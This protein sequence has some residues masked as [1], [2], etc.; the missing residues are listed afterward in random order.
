M[1]QQVIA[2]DPPRPHKL[3]RK[4]HRDIE[5][6]CLK[7]M[8]KVPDRRYQTALEMTDDIDRFL[9]AMSSVSDRAWEQRIRR[10]LYVKLSPAEEQAVLAQFPP[11]QGQS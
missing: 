7:A 9:D 3:N 4:V 1:L 6:I 10:G 2:E 8:E 5:T 11:A